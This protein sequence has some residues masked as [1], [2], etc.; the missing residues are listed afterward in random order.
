[1]GLGRVTNARNEDH[2][3]NWEDRSADDGAGWRVSWEDRCADGRR[4]FV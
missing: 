1:M 4:G 2:V 3:V